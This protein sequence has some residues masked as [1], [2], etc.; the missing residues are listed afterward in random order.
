[1]INRGGARLYNSKGE[2][3]MRRYYP[4]T[5][6]KSRG[7]EEMTRAIGLEI[8]EGRGSA[9]G[10]VYL[11]VSDVPAEMQETPFS[12]FWKNAERAGIDLRYQPIELSTN[13]HD[14]V[15]GVKIDE[16]GCT[17]V[18]G[19]YA[20]GE[21]AGGAHGA[22]RFGGSALAEALAFGA[23]VGMNAALFVKEQDNQSPLDEGQFAE[24]EQKVETL[25]S[26]KEGIR[27]AELKKTIQSIAHNYLNVGRNEEGLKTALQ[28]LDHI[29]EE[30]LPRMT[31]SAE[32]Q[33]DRASKLLQA[34]EVDGQR[35]LAKIIATAALCRRESRGGYF[36]GHY[37]S[38]Y[39]DQD[40]KNWL[41]NI[42]LKRE[43]DGITLHFEPP[44]TEE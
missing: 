19:L 7:G 30:I 14:L 23:I 5:G 11:D 9:H 33:E 39:P 37:R 6:E 31:A 38:D 20:A 35:E 13:P 28:E 40:D 44:V 15:G 17:N 3:F 8:C 36:G 43:Q 26:R 21:A 12:K 27:P 16:K 25:L 18:H 4:D 1:L 42:I 29:E 22:S 34:I 2:R 24:V 41:K 10:G 32:D